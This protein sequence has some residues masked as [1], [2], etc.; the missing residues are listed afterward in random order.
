MDPS[1]D[2]HEFQG[3]QCFQDSDG[4]QDSVGR[5]RIPG[6]GA[7]CDT[8]CIQDMGIYN[9]HVYQRTVLL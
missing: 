5:Q 3:L 1:Q 2:Y 6:S 7:M 8:L 4:L 9:M